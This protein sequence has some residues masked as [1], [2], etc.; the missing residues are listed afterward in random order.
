VDYIT[1]KRSAK[2]IITEQIEDNAWENAVDFIK[3]QGVKLKGVKWAK[4]KLA[5]KYGAKGVVFA[6]KAA[7][8]AKVVAAAAVVVVVA[9]TGYYVY[10]QFNPKPLEVGDQIEAPFQIETPAP[11]P[12]PST[13]PT[14][15]EPPSNPDPD[16]EPD[17]VGGDSGLDGN[18]YVDTEYGAMF[19]TF[20]GNE[21]TIDMW[22]DI[23]KGTY[24]TENGFMTFEFD[25]PAGYG[26]L[27]NGAAYSL[28]GD[29]LTIDGQ[30]Y[31][32][33]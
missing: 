1:G 33:E 11:T 13:T 32:K 16:N 12:I 4:A 3:A 6:A 8:C 14:P 29:V 28:Y 2:T 19:L 17:P 24:K 22:G 23:I 10:T 26:I 9:G 30:D 31:V 5:V 25:E 21:V 20:S 7:V 15:T 27:A 18:T